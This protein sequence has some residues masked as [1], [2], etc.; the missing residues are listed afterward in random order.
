MAFGK[1]NSGLDMSG[2]SGRGKSRPYAHSQKNS[3]LTFAKSSKYTRSTAP[4]K[5]GTAIKKTPLV[6]K[7]ILLIIVIAVFALLL[8]G[9]VGV[10]VYKQTVKD[11]IRP[12]LDTSSLSSALVAPS[13][14]ATSF[15]IAMTQTDAKSSL[16]KSGTAKKIALCHV[17]T[18]NEEITFLWI[19]TN[20]RMYLE[21]TGYMRISDL[22]DSQHES[23]V[24]QALASL[25]DVDIAHYVEFSETGLSEYASVQVGMKLPDSSKSADDIA[26]SLFTKIFGSSSE[27]MQN[28]V[29]T[30]DKYFA[31][32]MSQDTL[33]TIF[34]ELQGM[35]VS[36]NYSSATM[37]YTD[38][39]ENSVDYAVPESSSWKT[40]VERVANGLGPIASKKEVSSNK[41]LRA[42]NEVTVWNGAGVTGIAADCV[43][44][45]K[46]LGWKVESSGNAAQFVYEE[47]LVVYKKDSNKAAAKLLVSD[48]GQ[49]RTVASA[50]RY[51]FDGDLLVVVGKDYMPY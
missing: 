42:S 5:H 48:L 10:I 23:G 37:P 21:G 32:D 43:E 35:D 34:T 18:E 4:R 17:D 24:V 44:Q 46:K 3:G 22:Y 31:S 14:S 36:E 9:I 47:T 8:A 27:E 13:D 1:R 51:S 11:S 6:N 15:W 26:S 12:S 40:M 30:F 39:N 19:P 28:Q 49:G 41:D 33:L 50:Y 16:G 29:E 45:V 7:H 38:E 25:A 20:T 2:L